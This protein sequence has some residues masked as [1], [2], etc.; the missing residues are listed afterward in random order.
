M[1]HTRY[2]VE[3]AGEP[4]VFPPEA[5]ARIEKILTRYPTKQAALLPVLTSDDSLR[6]QL[7]DRANRVRPLTVL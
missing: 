7:I 6:Y 3:D 4:R 2:R 1:S 5:M